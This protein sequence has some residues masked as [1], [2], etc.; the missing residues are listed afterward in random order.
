MT[1]GEFQREYEAVS[2]RLYTFLLRVTGDANEAQD[3]L[4]E[5]VY[6]AYRKRTSF[7]RESGFKTWIYRIALNIRANNMRR[8]KVEQDYVGH[9]TMIETTRS[10]LTPEQLLAESERYQ[11][12]EKAL[13]TLKEKYTIPL[14]LK[15]QE[16]YSYAEI[17][18]MLGIEESA[19]RKRVYRA[20]HQLQA[21]LEEVLD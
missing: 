17:S 19:V 13:D 6:R 18:K 14:L 4:Q 5:A 7:R 1:S 21:H 20:R 9:G 16:G 3:L 15:H 8:R 10:P 2:S 11:E 12:L